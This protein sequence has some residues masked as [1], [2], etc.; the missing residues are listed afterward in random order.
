M[1]KLFLCFCLFLQFNFGSKA[2]SIIDLTSTYLVLYSGKTIKCTHIQYGSPFFNTN[3]GIYREDSVK[4][5]K[6]SSGS[7]AN[8]KHLSR[9]NT[10]SFMRATTT[11][12]I[13]LYSQTI[14]SVKSGGYKQDR[15]TGAYMYTRDQ[16]MTQEYLY[17]NKGTGSLK[18]A[19]YKTL[20]FDLADNPKS[21]KQLRKCR[22]IRVAEISIYVLSLA[23]AT[24]GIAA[25]FEEDGAHENLTYVGP[26]VA[27]LMY[28]LVRGNN[29]K[30]KKIRKAIEAYNK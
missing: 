10:S 18:K 29:L 4:F 17:Y 28:Y 24:A 26:P 3:V 15:K 25:I 11:G 23:M 22:N 30:Q 13:N 8:T 20:K 2:Q 9:R 12:P 21:M 27:I 7:F 14:T 1:K 5:Y 19:K 16:S 6:N